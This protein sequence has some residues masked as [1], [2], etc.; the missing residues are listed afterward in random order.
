M[1]RQSSEDCTRARAHNL[2]LLFGKIWHGKLTQSKAKL[3]TRYVAQQHH[4]MMT[5]ND[6]ISFVGM[7]LRLGN[8]SIVK[9]HAISRNR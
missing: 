5:R 8:C 7:F 9:T 3:I 6:R 1:I 4:L 2:Y